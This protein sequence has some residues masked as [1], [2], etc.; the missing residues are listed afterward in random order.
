MNRFIFI[1]VNNNIK[2]FINKCKKYSIELHNL[3]YINKDKIIVKIDKNDYDLIKKY[4]YYSEINIY[5]KIGLDNIKDKIFNQ[6][7][8]ILLFIFLLVFM[9]FVS[10]II[11]KINVIH[12]NK[13]IRELVISELENYGIKK[14]SYKKSFNE[15]EKIKKQILDNNKNKLEWISITNVGMTTVIRVE[16][17]IID[18]IK[19]SKEYCNIISTKDS[20]ITNIYG[21]KGEIIVNVNDIVKPNDILISG[22]IL[23]NEENKGY[24]CATGKVMGK[25]WY[26]TSIT[27]ERVYEK[28]EYTSKTRFNFTL[29]N[30]ILRNIKYK[31]YDKKYLIKTKYFSIYKELEYKLK[32]YKYNEKESIEKALLE[33]DNK[34]KSKLGK[35]GKILNKKIL[36][37]SMNNNIV[38]LKLFIIPEEDISK[39]EVLNISEINK[40]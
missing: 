12:S 14:Y 19:K 6:K 39:Q 22:N 31:N 9:Y 17:R 20:L 2:R 32:K 27:L 7:Y 35:N 3:N 16:E 18:E 26:N 5:K 11:F 29:N 30:K 40:E 34:F 1:E 25:V 36:S 28:K 4:N 38:E 37:K 33:I 13:N 15:L 10:N 23:L 8:F 21:I 24:I